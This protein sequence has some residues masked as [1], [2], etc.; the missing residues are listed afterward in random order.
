MDTML[1]YFAKTERDAL[2][3]LYRC[4]CCDLNP[5]AFFGLLSIQSVAARS[6][7]FVSFDLYKRVT[8]FKNDDIIPKRVRDN[9]KSRT[10]ILACKNEY[11]AYTPFGRQSAFVRQMGC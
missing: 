1:Y 4:L 5:L 11:A 9:A 8:V 3:V 7:L 6:L 10:A 2:R